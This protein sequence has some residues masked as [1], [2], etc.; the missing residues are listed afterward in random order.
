MSEN[1]KP[2]TVQ[3]I[4]ERIHKKVDGQ[5]AEK[6]PKLLKM[7]FEMIEKDEQQVINALAAIIEE[8]EVKITEKEGIFE[9]KKIK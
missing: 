8:L 6:R 2:K 5:S 4:I 9:I 7:E 3:E 1:K